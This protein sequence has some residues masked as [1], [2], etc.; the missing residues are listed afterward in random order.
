MISDDRTR[1]GRS[2]FFFAVASRSYFLRAETGQ[3]VRVFLGWEWG[4]QAR[5]V[6]TRSS[7][8][9]LISLHPLPGPHSVLFKEGE[10]SRE[11]G[12]DGRRTRYASF[13]FFCV[14]FFFFFSSVLF[15]FFFCFFFFFHRRSPGRT[16]RPR[17]I[18]EKEIQTTEP[19][20]GETPTSHGEPKSTAESAP[21]SKGEGRARIP[22]P[23][24]PR[25]AKT[26]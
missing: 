2:S 17:R 9:V 22:R 25:R 6:A 13:F 10:R 4:V 1:P 26:D 12:T 11:C 23:R 15:L 14:F 16:S 21:A 18:R 24:S 3:C 20:T 7:G 19:R 5:K 8:S